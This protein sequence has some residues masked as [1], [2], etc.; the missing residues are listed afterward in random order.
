M[1]L[2]HCFTLKNSPGSSEADLR[3]QGNRLPLRFLPAFCESESLVLRNMSVYMYALSPPGVL[4]MF[5]DSY[6]ILHGVQPF[7]WALRLCT[8]E[9]SFKKCSSECQ[10][11]PTSDAV[12]VPRWGILFPSSAQEKELKSLKEAPSRHSHQCEGLLTFY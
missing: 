4:F 8:L 9:S 2:R 3:A 6:N 7:P 12:T 11:P 10:P 1:S 5:Q